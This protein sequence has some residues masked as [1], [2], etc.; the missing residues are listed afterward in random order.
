M[1]NQS[2]AS[3]SQQ[4]KKK[5]KLPLRQLNSLSLQRSNRVQ[6][7]CD[8]RRSWC[9]LVITAEMPAP[10]MGRR[11]RK[12]PDVSAAS[13]IKAMIES[14]VIPPLGATEKVFVSA[15]FE[16]DGSLSIAGEKLLTRQPALSGARSSPSLG[17]PRHL[18]L[19]CWPAVCI[20]SNDPVGLQK[21]H[22]STSNT[23]IR[24]PATKLVAL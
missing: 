21:A 6:R 3:G 10:G 22:I 23:I 4:S 16:A 8:E 1:R 17:N 9:S 11:G 18:Y 7:R 14:C 19:P 12:Q 2:L 5:F 15:T 20:S 13:E 24:A